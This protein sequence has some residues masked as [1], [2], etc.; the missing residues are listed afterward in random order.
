MARILLVDDDP[1]QL[2]IRKLL[3]KTEGHEVWTAK[4]AP[5]AGQV[6]GECKPELVVMDL[7]LPR[8]EDGQELIREL[9][10]RSSSVRIVVLSGLASDLSQLPEAGLVDQVLHK[11]FRTERLLG[12]ISKLTLLCLCVAIGVILSV[13]QTDTFRLDRPA[14]VVAELDMSSPGAGR[15]KIPTGGLLS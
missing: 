10:A 1:D 12:L 6:F 4:T 9:R 11:P 2:E 8:L 5:A 7:R 3:L 13:E 14:E 15:W